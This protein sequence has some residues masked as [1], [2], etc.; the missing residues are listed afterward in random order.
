MRSRTWR[1]PGIRIVLAARSLDKLEE[2][3]AE[4]SAAGG[5]AFAVGVGSGFTRVH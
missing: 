2:V 4:I 1:P 5:E 3:A